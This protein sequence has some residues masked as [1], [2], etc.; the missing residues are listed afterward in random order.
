MRRLRFMPPTP[1]AYAPN[2]VHD[3][4]QFGPIC[5]QRFP[6]FA[7]STDSAD[8]Y[9]NQ[10]GN[11]VDLLAAAHSTLNLNASASTGTATATGT[12]TET[13]A[14]QVTKPRRTKATSSR[15]KSNLRNWE[16]TE[17]LLELVMQK[18]LPEELFWQHKRQMEQLSLFNQSEDCL[19]LN[20]FTPEEGKYHLEMVVVVVTAAVIYKCVYICES[21]IYYS[22][23]F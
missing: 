15:N 16:K 22:G 5:P 8:H 6:M 13:K 20:I 1:F 4:R 10:V 12:E 21:I 23:L 11:F 19:N 7:L 17:A 2:L 3:Q 14:G 9:T 18:I